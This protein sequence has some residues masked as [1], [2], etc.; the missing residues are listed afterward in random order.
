[1]KTITTL[2]AATLATAAAAA[3]D[4]TA[5]YP[6]E[7]VNAGATPEFISSGAITA[8]FGPAGSLASNSRLLGTA[9]LRVRG[10]LATAAIPE[11]DDGA[12][13]SNNYDWSAADTRTIAFWMRANGQTDP[14]AT[15]ISL[16]NTITNGARFDIRLQTGATVFNAPPGTSGLLRLEVQGGFVESTTADFTNAGLSFTNLRDNRW[17]H[18][19]VVVPTATATVHQTAFNIDGVPVAHSNQG[20]N[21]AINTAASPLRIG[22]SYQDSGR[23]FNGYLDDV[24]VYNLALTAQEV[25]DLYNSGVANASAIAAFEAAPELLP[26]GASTQLTW[27]AA[28]TATAVAIDHGVGDVTSLTQTNA[29]VNGDG[30]VTYTLNVTTPSG[31]ETASLDLTVLGPPRLIAGQLTPSGFS[32]T[33]KNL[34]PGTTYQAEYSLTL[35]ADSWLPLG[36]SFAGPPTATLTLNDGAANPAIDPKVFY[37]VREVVAE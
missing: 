30:T 6:F 16:G 24:R 29:T 31:T 21:Q 37:R 22:D 34:V 10:Q 15:M 1:M 9:S 13:T 14:L 25:L 26:S 32:F 36:S 5:L 20:T 35:E 8:A 2:L 23:D 11:G 28:A 3:I 12:I 4:P 27:Q 33:A 7:S 17:H 18:I 19:A